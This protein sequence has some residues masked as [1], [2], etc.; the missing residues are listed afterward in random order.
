MV[1]FLAAV[2]FTAQNRIPMWKLA[3]ASAGAGVS[4]YT[5]FPGDTTA[6]QMLARSDNALLHPQLSG[7]KKSNGFLFDAG[8]EFSLAAA[9]RLRSGDQYNARRLLRLGIAYANNQYL[10]A[11]YHKAESVRFDTL[12]SQSGNS[13]DLYLDSVFSYRYNFSFSM[14]RAGLE[15]ALLFNT[16]TGRLFGLFGGV[17]VAQFFSTLNTVSIQSSEMQRITHSNTS[18]EVTHSEH[19][20]VSNGGQWEELE[21]RS[22][23]ST[24]IGIPVGG[25]VRLSRKRKVLKNI[26]LFL[27]VSPMVEF[28]V[29]PSYRTFT[30]AATNWQGGMRV[31]FP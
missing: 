21:A 3:W 28:T 11:S 24:R 6:F 27:Q 9:F 2:A 18:G 16:D 15:A 30:R 22:A 10:S 7:Y 29:I 25:T 13:G 26:Q 31:L 1:M 4:G 20:P 17:S 5:G 19:I 8:S 14:R 12:S 23:F